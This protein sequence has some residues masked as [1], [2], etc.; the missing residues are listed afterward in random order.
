[1]KE[2]LNININGIR[3]IINNDA[4]DDLKVYLDK[5]EAAYLKEPSGREIVSDI[6]ARIAELLLSWQSDSSKIVNKECI[7]EI[8]SRLGEPDGGSSEPIEAPSREI[9]IEK[10]LYR[11]G[12]GSVLGGVLSG[13]S[14]Y[15]KVDVTI[16]RIAFVLLFVLGC[17]IGGTLV[18]VLFIAYFVMWIIVPMAK[19]ARQKM[20]M[21][22]EPVT[23]SSIEN[24]IKNE[25]NNV[26]KNS[27]NEKVASVFSNILVF[28]GRIIKGFLFFIAA[29]IGVSFLAT[30]LAILAVFVYV[31]TDIPLV[32]MCV[33]LNPYLVLFVATVS[34]IVP[35]LLIL[36]LIIKMLLNIRW[37]K[38]IIIVLLSLW[39]ISWSLSTIF[40]FKELSRFR[41]GYFEVKTT[42]MITHS[43]ALYVNASINPALMVANV[44]SDRCDVNY[45]CVE[46]P[47]LADSVYRIEVKTSAD[48]RDDMDARQ[49]ASKIE[50]PITIVSDST[51]TINPKMIING[52]GNVFS[53]QNIKIKIY[54]PKGGK[55]V[56][57]EELRSYNS[58]YDLFNDHDDSFDE[59]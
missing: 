49:R 10:R 40:A 18:S 21:C 48:G 44:L 50:N 8:I 56:V 33:E 3:F 59:N 51:I 20:E 34:V 46:D 5:I 31:L 57:D 12:Y 22:G 26:Y 29:I 55:V 25:I 45:S 7:D 53:N 27:K 24:G 54:Y 58:C 13:L 47:L 52:S 32:E 38:S 37:K 42:E 14:C 9:P 43:S 28:L 19:T 1:M 11:S 16:L 35:L 15:F 30:V 41:D 39:V 17:A 4:Y 36:Y 2:T 23:A 6:E